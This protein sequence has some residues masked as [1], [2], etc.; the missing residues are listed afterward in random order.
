MKRSLPLILFIIFFAS[1]TAT[2]VSESVKSDWY[3]KQLRNKELPAETRIA[4]IDSIF[5]L[6]KDTLNIGLLRQRGDL[7]FEIGNYKKSFETFKVIEPL[8]HKDSV[9]RVLYT[10]WMQSINAF[11][12]SNYIESTEKAFEILSTK[13]PAKYRDFDI[14][15]YCVL[16]DF[17]HLIGMEEQALKYVDSALG[18]LDD[19][20]ESGINDKERQFLKSCMFRERSG[21]ML[22]MGNT[23]EAYA[24]AVRARNLLNGKEN[25][26][27]YISFADISFKNND[28]PTA[29]NYYR[30]A[31][32]IHTYDFNK[33]F[34]ILGLMRIYLKQNRIAEFSQ[35]LN[36]WAADIKKIYNGPLEAEYLTVMSDFYEASGRHKDALDALK[37]VAEINDSVTKT[38]ILPVAIKM[39]ND[40]EKEIDREKVNALKEKNSIF[41]KVICIM[42]LICLTVVFVVVRHKRLLK[43]RENEIINLKKEKEDLSDYH[44]QVSLE[45]QQS[46]ET[47]GQQLSSM[48]IYMA[49]MNEALH[50]V[51]QTAR[52]SKKPEKERLMMIDSSLSELDR[53]ENV[54]KMF[55]TYFEQV[56]QSFFNRLY[57]LCPSLTKAET[58]MCA[59]IL[60]NLST[61][62]IATMT[63]R[64]VRTVETIKHNLRKKL[65]IE[66]TESSDSFMRRIA[67][68][69][70]AEFFIMCRKKTPANL[71]GREAD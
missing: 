27:N 45:N 66:L 25:V 10:K 44:R 60:L 31:L 28:L 46:I 59:F 52:D 67:S 63:N 34:A 22:D 35:L 62:E 53:E 40:F 55:R 43:K 39:A 15:A 16:A 68:C 30:E 24:D 4:Y 11:S 3:A 56:N 36:D 19:K 21:I 48:T 50:N 58:R 61:K 20:D 32:T 64:S 14:K 26:E 41:I 12:F 2:K 57:R 5:S 51:Q 13:K 29:E 71:P 17:Y 49:R 23:D 65:G 70:D 7:Y 1:A 54:W 6:T 37:R 18:I 69:D 47:Q 38:T 9:G 42:M 33:N 8:L